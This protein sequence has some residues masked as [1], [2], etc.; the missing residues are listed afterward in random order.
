MYYVVDTDRRLSVAVPPSL[1]SQITTVNRLLRLAT[2]IVAA[3]D[4]N[5]TQMRLWMT[6]IPQSHVA[7]D[8]Q[9]KDWV[10]VLRPFRKPGPTLAGLMALLWWCWTVSVLGQ[11]GSAVV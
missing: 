8:P 2:V 1:L 11:H 5:T 4:V 10:A 9:F 6:S 3:A 7:V